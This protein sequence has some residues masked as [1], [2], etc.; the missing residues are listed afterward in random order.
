[1]PRIFVSYRRDDS[2]YVAGMLTERLK[3][4]FGF[5]SVFIDVEAIPLGADFRKNISDAVARSDVFLALIGDA[6]QGSTGQTGRAIDDPDDFVRAEIEA[7]LRE[8]IP[9]IPVLVGKARM[10]AGAELPESLRPLAFRNAAEVRSGRD[11]NHHIETLIDDLQNH[12]SAGSAAVQSLQ[13][14]NSTAETPKDPCIGPADEALLVDG[15]GAQ[16]VPRR[17]TRAARP[18]FLVVATLLCI[19]IAAAVVLRNDKDNARRD[20]FVAESPS[21]AISEDAATHAVPA[22]PEVPKDSA[23][24]TAPAAQSH[25]TSK[26]GEQDEHVAKNRTAT[27]NVSPVSPNKLQDRKA[28][29]RVASGTDLSGKWLIE[30]TDKT[31]KTLITLRVIN[32]KVYGGTDIDFPEYLAT[33]HGAR[34]HSSIYDGELTP[35]G[36]SFKTKRTIRTEAGNDATTVETIDHYQGELQGNKIRFFVSRAGGDY[37]EV[38]AVKTL[39]Q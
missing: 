14:A 23:V 15:S 38:T 11:M 24:R 36:L 34:R 5:D 19:A 35:N 21:G 18:K 6:W 4:V 32:G 39:S 7:A 37:W 27:P 9:I 30:E 2:G 26:P 16:P 22:A 28:D 12:F 33:W 31:F 29:A 8:H 3:K 17:N 1:M 13:P 20:T 10:P 25:S